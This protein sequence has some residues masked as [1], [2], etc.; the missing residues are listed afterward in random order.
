MAD[1]PTF[2]ENSEPAGTAWKTR[3]GALVHKIRAPR[4]TTSVGWFCTG[5]LTSVGPAPYSDSRIVTEAQAHAD[6]CT[7][8]QV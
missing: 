8:V 7:A 4:R 3:S 6:G 5:C 2:P 1:V